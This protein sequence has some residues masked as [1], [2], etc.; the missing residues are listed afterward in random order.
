[1]FDY[2]ISIGLMIHNHNII[3]IEHDALGLKPSALSL[4]KFFDILG[5]SCNTEYYFYR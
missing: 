1:M 5:K 3:Y 4:M 2:S